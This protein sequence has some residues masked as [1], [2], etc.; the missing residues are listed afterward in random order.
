MLSA[1]LTARSARDRG[2][3]V[4]PRS[5]LSQVRRCTQCD[6]WP[7]TGSRLCGSSLRLALRRP[8]ASKGKGAS[9]SGRS[10]FEP[11]GVSTSRQAAPPHGTLPE[12]PAAM[13]TEASTGPTS[14][15][16]RLAARARAVPPG[17]AAAVRIGI[18]AL[19]LVGASLV[20]YELGWFDYRHTLEHIS[21]L[22]AHHNVLVFSISFVLIYGL[23]TSVG[24]PSLPFTVA[25]GV[26]FGTALG[27]TF[28]WFG[29]LVSGVV[30][31]W[32]ACSI[33]HDIVARWLSR[34]RRASAAI[35]DA[36]DFDG[37]L[38][39]RLIPVLPLGT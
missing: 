3:R 36:R 19:L 8:S 28:S 15:R 38:R 22:R 23:G 5:A 37:I 9:P 32:V 24:M 33:G 27:S 29:E 30:G 11:R 16:A 13:S 6:G 21:R 39:L 7:L 10:A 34:Y 18:L 14:A 4:A 20:A 2:F 1:E 25:A 35:D 12:L 17:R 31:Y 26:L